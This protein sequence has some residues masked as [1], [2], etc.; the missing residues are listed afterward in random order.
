MGLIRPPDL[1]YIAVFWE[2][3]R[4]DQ[5]GECRWGVALTWCQMLAHPGP[6]IQAER[7]SCFGSCLCIRFD[8]RML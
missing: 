1:S 6:E 7:S 8:I 3:F 4:G 5:A 2:P